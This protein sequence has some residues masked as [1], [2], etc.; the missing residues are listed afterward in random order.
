M[1][2]PP[3]EVEQA[4]NAIAAAPDPDS[5]V[6]AIKHYFTE[7]ASFVYPICYVPSAPNSISL[8]IA[9]YI[10]Y[11][12]AIPITA[13][14]V[15]SIGWDESNGKL[16]VDLIQYPWMRGTTWLTG[17]RP[18]VE[19]HVHLWLRK[20]EDDKWRISKQEDTIQP[21]TFLLAFPVLATIATMTFAF[22]GYMALLNVAIFQRFGFWRPMQDHGKP[23]MT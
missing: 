16:F 11:R 15:T 6:K 5:Q 7:D 17:W 10:F 13:F 12:I 3:G 19:M 9:I 21:F 22:A 14:T 23:K 20:G 4:I 18:A 2:D 1:N 8:I